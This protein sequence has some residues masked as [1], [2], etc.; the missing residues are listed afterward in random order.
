MSLRDHLK[1]MV[2][3]DMSTSRGLILQS[4]EDLRIRNVDFRKDGTSALQT[5][6]AHP[7][8]LVISD[9]NMPGLDG[10]GLLKELRGNVSTQWIGFILISGIATRAT[11]EQGQKLGMNNF[12]KKPF[13]TESLRQCMQAVVGAL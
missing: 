3:D 11:I 12:L 7:V 2:V 1:I 9:Y 8:H 13:T 10:L 6:I 4:L 5:L